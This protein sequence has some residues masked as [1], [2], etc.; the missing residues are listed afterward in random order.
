MNGSEDVT[1][2]LVSIN[3][4][5]LDMK[6]NTHRNDEKLDRI[7]NKVNPSAL[8][9]ELHQL[10]LEK[11]LP[12]C[13]SIVCDFIWPVMTYNVAGLGDKHSQLQKLLSSV[14]LL[15]RDLKSNYSA[16][17]KRSTSPPPQLS[18]SQQPS[19]SSNIT[20]NNGL[21]QNMSK[22]DENIDLSFTNI[23]EVR[24]EALNI[25]TSDHWPLL[26]TFK[27]VGFE[28]NKMFPH[29]N[30]KAYEVILTLLQEFWTNEQNRG[31]PVDEWYMNYVRFLAAL[32]VRLTQWKEKEKVRSSLLPYL[33]Q[34]LKESKSDTGKTILT[35]ENEISDK[36]YRYYSEQFKAQ[37]ADI[38][39]PHENQIETAYLELMNKLPILNEK[40]E[41]TNF[42][43]MK[44]AHFKLETEKI[45]WFRCSV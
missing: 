21:D 22:M 23:D 3:Q 38:S 39:D 43:E 4:N 45:I 41:M 31:M 37:N 34:K 7:N 19:K 20:T 8:D 16:R 32:K 33:I 35:K 17:R 25:D 24:E 42:T 2:M 13:V 44:K 28:K 27:N 30:W 6:E 5:I 18:P 14:D 40:I 15:L 9:T 10:T 11:L 1:K 12:I 26:I 29:V 36:L